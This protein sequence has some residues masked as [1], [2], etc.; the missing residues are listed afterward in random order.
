MIIKLAMQQLALLLLCSWQTAWAEVPSNAIWIDV[1]SP[2]EYAA[3]H[4]E[5]AML[6]PFDEIEVGVAQLQ[7]SRETPIYLYCA[8]GGRAE[9]AKKRLEA[10]NY[11]NVTNVGGLEEAR[12]LV[13]EA[14]L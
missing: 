1:R 3:G 10:Q 2:S 4:L 12:E 9:L 7:L 11:V 5:R 8:V 6:I 13:S 14:G